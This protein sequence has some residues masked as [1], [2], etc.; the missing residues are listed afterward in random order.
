M[1]L[2]EEKTAFILVLNPEKLPIL[3]S[4]KALTVLHQFQVPV[5]AAVVNRV[6]PADARGSFLDHR[7]RQ[8]AEYLAEIER[9]FASLH[10]CY[11][12]PA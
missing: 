4:K 3:E 6:L 7:R 5:V 8:E 1:L 2:D 9:E 11:L 12:R 10:R